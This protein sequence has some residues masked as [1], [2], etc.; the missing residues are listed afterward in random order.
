MSHPYSP[1]AEHSRR[2]AVAVILRDGRFLVI[3]RSSC[4]VAPGAYCFPGG[5]IE[6]GESE[7]AALVREIREELA[8]TVEP[9]RRIWQSVTP[10]G[11][12]LSWWLGR[13]ADGQQPVP[14]PAEVDCFFWLSPAEMLA[15]PELLESNR[16][17]LDA[18]ARGEIEIDLSL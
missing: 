17:F 6:A 11:V 3:R 10:W 5:A 16:H 8:V 18:I 14:N 7:Q 1:P 4:V 13:L 12:H 9:L 2:G 15:R